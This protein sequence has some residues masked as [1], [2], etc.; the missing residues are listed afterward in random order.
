MHKLFVGFAGFGHALIG[1]HASDPRLRV[2][3]TAWH[4]RAQRYSPRR[5]DVRRRRAGRENLPHAQ[6][7]PANVCAWDRDCLTVEQLDAQVASTPDPQRACHCRKL[8]DVV[9]L[10]LQQM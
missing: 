6:R 10:L 9:A 5:N 4:H 2:E 1:H 8:V 7:M 3:L